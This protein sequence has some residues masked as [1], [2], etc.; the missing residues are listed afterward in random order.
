LAVSVPVNSPV[1]ALYASERA[2]Y[3]AVD[4]ELQVVGE[5]A[6]QASTAAPVV[7]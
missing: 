1:A 2:T 3:S 7:A 4:A 6:T 5:P